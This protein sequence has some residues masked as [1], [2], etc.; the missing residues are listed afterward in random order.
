M[1]PV[2]CVDNR[3]I[4]K[5]YA[6]LVVAEIGINHEGSMEKARKMIDDAVFV[7]C[8]CVKFQSHVIEDEMTFHARKVIPGNA[9]N[10]IWEI[11]ARCSFNEEQERELMDYAEN[12]GLIYLSTPF[13]REAALR[14]ERLGVSAFKIGSGECNNLPLVE[15]IASFRKPVILSTGMNDLTSINKSVDILRKNQV[16]YALL[17][18]TSIYPTPFEKVRLG[19]MVQLQKAFPDAVIGLSDH[20]T[21]I[22]PAL[23]AVALGASLIERHFTSDLSWP[24]PDIPISMSPE[25][26]KLLIEGSKIIHKSLGGEK[27]IL[28]E[29][30]S[31][32]AFAYASVVAISDI[33]KGDIFTAENLWVKRPG[34]GEIKA[35]QLNKL[36]GKRAAQNIT[37]DTQIRWDDIEK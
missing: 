13:S 33:N 12:K 37:K 18:C 23:G 2:I 25:D 11:M 7:G 8:E 16:P 6:P 27:T 35:D 29:E 10:S 20:S 17:H 28:E 31:T 21:S 19:A 4:G 9:E 26:L 15:V 34:T 24:G 5:K 30:A 14:L 32:I 22:F 3:M 1:E 36:L